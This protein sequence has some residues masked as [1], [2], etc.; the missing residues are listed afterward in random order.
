MVTAALVQNAF[1]IRKLGVP[2]WCPGTTPPASNKLSAGAPAGAWT[3]AAAS[4]ATA[5]S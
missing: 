5:T 3:S 2:V 1:E 4:S